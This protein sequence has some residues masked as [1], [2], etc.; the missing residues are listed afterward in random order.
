MENLKEFHSNQFKAEKIKFLSCFLLGNELVFSSILMSST[1][2]WKSIPWAA[3]HV[4]GSGNWTQISPDCKKLPQFQREIIHSLH[5]LNRK[6]LHRNYVVD[7]SAEWRSNF[8]IR[9]L[10]HRLIFHNQ[11]PTLRAIIKPP[12]FPHPLCTRCFFY[13]EI[14]EFS[15]AIRY[16]VSKT[17]S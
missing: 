17:V 12:K 13:P 11:P 1:T 8:P 9:Q 14:G 3:L 15:L 16:R 6:A 4:S 5:L 7:F 10:I 2:D